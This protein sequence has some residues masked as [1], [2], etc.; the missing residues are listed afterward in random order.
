MTTAESLRPA[1][2]FL[3][4]AAP[5]TP[6]PDGLLAHALDEDMRLLQD[7]QAL[8][9]LRDHVADRIADLHLRIRDEIAAGSDIAP[10]LGSCT[11]TEVTTARNVYGDG[12]TASSTCGDSTGFTAPTRT[13]YYCNEGSGCDEPLGLS[14]KHN[15]TTLTEPCDHVKGTVQTVIMRGKGNGNSTFLETAH[16]IRGFAYNCQG[17]SGLTMRIRHGSGDYDHEVSIP[18]NDYAGAFFAGA[19]LL[20]ERANARDFINHGAWDEGISISDPGSASVEYS[21]IGS[22]AVDD[23][24]IFCAD[25]Q[26]SLTM[27]PGNPQS[28]GHPVGLSWCNGACS[29]G[30]FCF[31]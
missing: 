27:S 16:R 23:Y 9:E 17:D 3:A 7:S 10:K 26:Q 25:V 19:G 29:G 21:T 1:E 15:C 24:G 2:L 18:V 6:L 14:D 31:E 4:L 20:Q 5:R 13:Y 22:T 8:Q 11:N 30:D 12:Y 28:C